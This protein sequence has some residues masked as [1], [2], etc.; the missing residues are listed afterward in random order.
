MRRW[1]GRGRY[2][3]ILGAI[4]ASVALAACTGT[5]APVPANPQIAWT[6]DSAVTLPDSIHGLV[7]ATGGDLVELEVTVFD[8]AGTDSTPELVGG[9]TAP[10]A[11][12]LTEK[13]AWKVL[14][15]SP[16]GYVRFS[17]IVFD[18]FGDSVVVRDSTLVTS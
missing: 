7:V 4:G 5:A 8:T 6:L 15:T 10:P 18:S 13:F 16:G 11:T 12:K 17:A 2:V 14:H 3:A 9:G 1:A